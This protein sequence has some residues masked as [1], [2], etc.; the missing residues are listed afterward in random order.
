MVAQN[1]LGWKRWAVRGLRL[2]TRNFPVSTGKGQVERLMR[3]LM[4]NLGEIDAISAYGARFRL[5]FP[6]DRGWE[7][8]YMTGAYETGTS[9]L[10]RKLLRPGDITFDVGANL[11]WYTC[12]FASVVGPSGCVHAFEPVPWI[13]EKLARNCALNGYTSAVTLNNLAI[14]KSEGVIELFSFKGRPHGETS[15]VVR[16]GLAVASSAKVKVI[17]LDSYVQT[18][19]ITNIALVKVA[20]EGAEWDML[21]G[22][23]SLLHSTR[24]PMWI[25]EINTETAAAFGWS[26]RDLLKRL[27]RDYGYSFVRIVGAWG[28]WTSLE[29]TEQAQ[30]GDNILCFLPEQHGDRIAGIQARV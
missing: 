8:L 9:E 7:C 17:T 6:D 23:S 27:Q 2:Y 25:L 21:D 29:S 10:C 13:Y 3:R 22:A 14:G 19:G 5:R 1:D 15:G 30:H 16:E 12:L 11:G 20:I 28:K 26:P 4:R 24:P 18:L